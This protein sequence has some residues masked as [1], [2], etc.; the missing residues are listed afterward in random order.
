MLNLWM[1]VRLNQNTLNLVNPVKI[2]MNYPAAELTGYQ[3]NLF[4]KRNA[5]SCGELTQK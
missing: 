2:E 4:S 3:P 5:A 1:D